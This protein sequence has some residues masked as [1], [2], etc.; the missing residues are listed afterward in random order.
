M[1]LQVSLQSTPPIICSGHRD[2]TLQGK[3][4]GFG[5]L[6]VNPSLISAGFQAVPKIVRERITFTS[7]A[8]CLVNGTIGWTTT[9]SK[10]SP[11]AKQINDLDNDRDFRKPKCA[12]YENVVH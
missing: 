5:R 2:R 12:D 11:L 3:A 9:F 1:N 6:P 10:R 4:I 7:I 8:N